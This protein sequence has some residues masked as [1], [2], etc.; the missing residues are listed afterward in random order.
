MG[1]LHVKKDQAIVLHIICLMPHYV[2]FYLVGDLWGRC[3]FWACSFRAGI[4]SFVFDIP[5]LRIFSC[6]KMAGYLH[7]ELYVLKSGFWDCGRWNL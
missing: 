5:T 3:C 6:V 2:L 4:H 1:F 7:P